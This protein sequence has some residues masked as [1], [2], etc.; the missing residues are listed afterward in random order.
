MGHLLPEASVQKVIDSFVPLSLDPNS[1]LSD[2]DCPENPS[3]PRS[4][5]NLARNGK[6]LG[7]ALQVSHCMICSYK[8]DDPEVRIKAEYFQDSRRSNVGKK[9]D[10]ASEPSLR[11][12]L[13]SH[14]PVVVEQATTSECQ[15]QSVLV[16]STTYTDQPNGLIKLQQCDRH[17][18]WSEAE[19]ELVRELAEQVGTAIAHATLYKELEEAREQAEAVSRLKSQFLANTTHELRTP[20]NGII[21]SLKLI[22]DGMVDTPEEQASFMDDAHRSALHLLDIINDILDIAKIEAGKMELELGQVK[23]NELLDDVRDFTH[24]QAQQKNLTFNIELPNTRDEIIVYGNYQRLLQI[25]LNLT[26]Q[27]DQIY[28]RRWGNY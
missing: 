19:V 17:R 8:P 7:K 22:I 13:F 9:L 3:Y 11:Q 15:K 6:S 23:L 12:A 28:P 2:S 10:L 25:L 27:C 24:N 26:G 4:G 14:E 21:C 16:V 18:I 5:H 1:K 20:L